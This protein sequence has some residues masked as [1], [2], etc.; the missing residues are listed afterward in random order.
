M[1][2]HYTVDEESSATA[3]SN[4]ALADDLWWYQ[5]FIPFKAVPDEEHDGDNPGSG[6]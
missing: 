1:N 5:S 6:E 3:D 4:A 2:Q